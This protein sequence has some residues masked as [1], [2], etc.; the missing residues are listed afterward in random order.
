MHNSG[1][2][3]EWSIVHP[4]KG[5]VPSSV[6]GVRIP[7]S[8][9]KD[10]LFLKKFYRIIALLKEVSQLTSNFDSSTRNRE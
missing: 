7:L 6:P 10:L 2:V 1:E 5:C 8:P 9:Q 4:W 3:S